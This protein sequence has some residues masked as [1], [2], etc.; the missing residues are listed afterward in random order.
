M[1]NEDSHFVTCQKCGKK[2]V[3]KLWHVNRGVLANKVIQH[4][5]PFCGHEMHR[6]GGGVSIIGWFII[7]FFVLPLVNAMF[8]GS[9]EA[10]NLKKERQ[11]LEL[12]I[13]QY[14]ESVEQYANVVRSLESKTENG[15][16]RHLMKQLKAMREMRDTY[17]SRKEE[18]ELKLLELDKKIKN[19]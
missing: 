12:S 14:K 19:L 17:I 1:V 7:I 5:C 6:S 16:N 11:S 8:F 3:P 18:K 13:K 10:L 2:S 9:S 15:Q 4:L